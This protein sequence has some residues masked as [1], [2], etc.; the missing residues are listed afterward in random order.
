MR[1]SFHKT[2]VLWAL[3]AVLVVLGLPSSG[4]ARP[5]FARHYEVRAQSFFDDGSLHGDLYIQEIAPEGDRGP[6]SWYVAVRILRDDQF[7]ES[8]G[9]YYPFA[10]S[11]EPRLQVVHAT[12]EIPTQYHYVDS[13]GYSQAIS[14]RVTFDVT[15]R[16][17]TPPRRL[18]AET[19]QVGT[20]IAYDRQAV[21]S[22]F[23][24]SP[25]MGTL[26]EPIVGNDSYPTVV[27]FIRQVGLNGVPVLPSGVCSYDL[28]FP[29]CV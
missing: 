12:G 9:G 29:I 10:L 13:N 24:S 7:G 17:T 1:G 18:N 21:A 26:S 16:A 28:P 27:T 2:R 3:A 22:G 5:T 23:M 6:V 14:S 19:P 25:Y 15:W 4:S 11:Y 8:G 20:T